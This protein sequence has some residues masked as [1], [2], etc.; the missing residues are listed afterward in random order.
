MICKPLTIMMPLGLFGPEPALAEHETIRPTGRKTP[1]TISA[2]SV[3]LMISLICVFK[4]T[5]QS[6]CHFKVADVPNNVMVL[7]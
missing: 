5:D 3:L 7:D 4:H 6:C 1:Q 2:V